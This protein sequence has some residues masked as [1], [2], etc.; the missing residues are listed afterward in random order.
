MVLYKVSAVIYAPFFLKDGKI[1]EVTHLLNFFAD[2]NLL[3]NMRLYRPLS[4][5]SVIGVPLTVN[6]SFTVLSSSKTWSRTAFCGL[7]YPRE[8]AISFPTNHG[9]PSIFKVRISPNSSHLNTTGLFLVIFRLADY[10]AAVVGIDFKSAAFVNTR[11]VKEF[12]WYAYIAVRRGFNRNI[13]R[14]SRFNSDNVKDLSV[15]FKIAF[16]CNFAVKCD[17]SYS[18]KSK[19]VICFSELIL[20]FMS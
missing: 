7:L 16:F 19:N 5:I 12:L 17:Y 4:F 6:D 9:S 11:F 8:T 2:G 3:D 20:S 10:D 15:R 13:Y 18:S 1:S 14:I